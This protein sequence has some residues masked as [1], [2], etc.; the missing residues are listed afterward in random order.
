M[1][2]EY[3]VYD[4]KNITP[5]YIVSLFDYLLINSN[6]D[7]IITARTLND[8]NMSYLINLKNVIPYNVLFN[9]SPK[10]L[11]ND[12]TNTINMLMLR[13][14]SIEDDTDLSESCVS[15]CYKLNTR[16]FNTID[17]IR[18]YLPETYNLP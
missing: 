18:T 3:P 2:W 1:S 11:Y 10:I 4:G 7:G 16:Y 9:I 5:Y 14:P 13:R 6:K 17:E 15:S 8:Y 12:D